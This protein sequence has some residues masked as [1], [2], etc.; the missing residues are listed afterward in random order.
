MEDEKEGK[1][2]ERQ[3]WTKKAKDSAMLCNICLDIEDLKPGCLLSETEVRP[4]RSGITVLS[5]EHPHF[6][7]L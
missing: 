7:A 3:I 6:M 5:P 4:T 1:E 2:G